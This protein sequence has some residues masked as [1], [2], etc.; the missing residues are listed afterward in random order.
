MQL[1]INLLILFQFVSS[2]VC[3]KTFNF[4]L[5]EEKFSFLQVHL[6]LLQCKLF[7]ITV[8]E[9]FNYII[10]PANKFYQT[11]KFKFMCIINCIVIL[12]VEGF[13]VYNSILF[14]ICKFCYLQIFFLYFFMLFFVNILITY[15]IAIFTSNYL[16]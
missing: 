15:Y 10:M 1:N 4:I 2:A 12:I 11:N 9:K 6:F 8:T 3:D 7:R 5:V 16:I 13:K 14:S